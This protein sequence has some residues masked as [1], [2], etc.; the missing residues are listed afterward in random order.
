[1]TA[2]YPGSLGELLI[3]RDGFDAEAKLVVDADRD[4]L[5]GATF[6]GPGVADLVQAATVAV[7]G[8]VPLSVLRHAIA[9]HPSL[10]QM[11]NA[12]LAAPAHS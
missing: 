5:L 12:L 1:M 7:V 8:E 3:Q 11:W 2:D 6:V 4:V 9:P 10:N